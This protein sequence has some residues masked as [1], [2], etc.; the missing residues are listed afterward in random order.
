MEFLSRIRQR[1]TRA[2]LSAYI[3]GEVSA[4]DARR[5]EEQAAACSESRDEIESLRATVELVSALPDLELPRSFELTSLPEEEPRFSFGVWAPRLATSVAGLLLVALVA[6]DFAGTLIPSGG[7]DEEA[8]ATQSDAPPPPA[9][10]AQAPEA[11][12]AAARQEAA[13]A[14]AAQAAPTQALQ[15]EQPDAEN[16]TPEAAQAASAPAAP[17]SM[18]RQSDAQ[19]STPDAEADTPAP[20]AKSRVPAAAQPSPEPEAA[21]SKEQAPEP[22]GPQ[23][24]PGVP[25]APED[26]AATQI[27]EPTAEEDETGV[28]IRDLQIGAAVCFL[29]LASVTVWLTRRRRRRI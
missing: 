19:E 27:W 21:A 1:R 2:L 10:M 28:T 16:A 18:A 14:M 22:S 11:P 9:A 6:A 29:A 25:G 15:L 12:A 23:G 17:A 8:T 7:F 5:V 4:A 26:V 3:D 20:A 24:A 13:P